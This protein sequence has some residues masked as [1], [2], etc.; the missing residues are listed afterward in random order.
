[1]L[2]RRATATDG[3]TSNAA[4]KVPESVWSRPLSRPRLSWITLSESDPQPKTAD[5]G[6][7]TPDPAL[8]SAKTE[9]LRDGR[10]VVAGVLGRGTQAETL[11]A[12]DRQ[13]NRRVAIKRFWVRGARSWKDVELAERE[14]R[15]LRDLLHPNLPVYV[16][17]FEEAGALYLVM[18][19]VPGDSLAAICRE[20]GSLDAGEII[21]L[22]EDLSKILDYLHSRVPPVIHRDIKPSNIIRRDD[23]G[24][25]LV[26]FGSVREKLRPEGGST[27]AG[28]FGYMAPEQFQ[29][30]AQPSSDVYAVGAT[31]LTVLTGRQPDELPHRGLSVDVGRALGHSVD[32][33]LRLALAAMLEP[34]P[35]HRPVSVTEALA[36][37]AL[38]S[39]ARKRIQRSRLRWPWIVTPAVALALAVPVF[40][41]THTWLAPKSTAR[42]RQRD[43]R[44]ASEIAQ[45]LDRGDPWSA[46]ATAST[47]ADHWSRAEVSWSLG[48]L[49]ESGREYL[50]ARAAEANHP[51]TMSELQAV[52]LADQKAAATLAMRAKEEWYHGPEGAA[53][54]QLEC[55]ARM[56]E[57]NGQYCQT[58]AKR[59]EWLHH[60]PAYALHDPVGYVRRRSVTEQ[61][62]ACGSFFPNLAPLS[63]SV[64]LGNFGVVRALFAAIADDHAMLERELSAIDQLMDRLSEMRAN[65]TAGPVTEADR[66]AIA[67]ASVSARFKEDWDKARFDAERLLSVAAAAAWFGHDLGRMRRYLRL[68]EAHSRGMLEEHLALVAGEQRAPR[69]EESPGD[70]NIVDME[71]FSLIDSSHQAQVVP[72]MQSLGYAS[73]ARV[74]ELF[75]SRPIPREALAQWLRAGLVPLCRTCG[76]MA[77]LEHNFNRREAARVVGDTA[78][79]ERLGQITRQLGA[80]LTDERRGEPLVALDALLV[81]E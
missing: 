80:V 1:M 4:K 25:V 61:G 51:V 35:E 5:P 10:Y 44:C 75:S 45:L 11:E 72:K 20:R 46:Q 30:R 63:E 65:P 18:Q 69:P 81:T 39:P 67:P 26:D 15:V 37:A 41:I 34:D 27:V 70:Y 79:A 38:A 7:A 36:N 78:L 17:H 68:A 58:A 12:E 29:G 21:R 59:S 64:C 23:G 42:S 13:A 8:P 71:L 54:A 16:E 50:R 14:A 31:V 53:Q 33:R 6:T 32:P 24:Y 56:L 76:V 55:V 73:P 57:K 66:A 62:M 19:C 47:C 60:Q 52:A 3:L 77:L 22:L 48:D 43:A 74:A 49:P 2:E 9:V 28:T 40:W